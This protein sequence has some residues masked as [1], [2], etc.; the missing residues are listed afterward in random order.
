M[1]IDNS[2]LKDGSWQICG[3]NEEI[4]KRWTYADPR[5]IKI[6]D[7]GMLVGLGEY[8]YIVAIVPPGFWSGYFRVGDVPDARSS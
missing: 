4:I 7:G 1:V 5:R 8:D 2:H 6:T 3:P